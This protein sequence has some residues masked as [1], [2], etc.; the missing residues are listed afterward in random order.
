MSSQNSKFQVTLPE[1][2][3]DQTVHYFM[4]P[5]SSGVSHSLSLS[6]DRYPPSD[7]ITVYAAERVEDLLESLPNAEELKQEER[8]MPD[9]ADAVEAV[10]KWIPSEDKIVFQKLVF[11]MRE[12]VAYTFK[13][14]FSKKTLKTVGPQVDEIINSFVPVWAG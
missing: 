5:D 2:W 3:E 13:A 8:P 10:I 4:G 7:D 14:D 9:G 1:G 6:I 11:L 12:D